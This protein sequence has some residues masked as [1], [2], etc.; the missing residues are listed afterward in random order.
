MVAESSL[1]VEPDL[2]DIREVIPD[3]VLDIRYATAHNFVGRPIEGYEAP[4]CLLTHRAAAALA[5]VQATLR[6]S[7]CR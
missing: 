3:V 1:L 7:A 2:V 5:G 4:L 6:P